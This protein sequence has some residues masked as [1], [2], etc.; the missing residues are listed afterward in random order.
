MSRCLV[1]DRGLL[2]GPLA[3]AGVFEQRD[4]VRGE[5]K[6]HPAGATGRRVLRGECRFTGGVNTKRHTNEVPGIYLFRFF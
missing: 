5:W 1:P 3:H 6:R 4:Q 2:R